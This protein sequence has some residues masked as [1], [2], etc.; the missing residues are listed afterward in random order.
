MPI[1]SP[2]VIFTA[3]T[4]SLRWTDDLNWRTWLS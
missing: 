3:G 1:S 4:W 2:I